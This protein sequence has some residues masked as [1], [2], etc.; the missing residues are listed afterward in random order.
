MRKLKLF[1]KEQVGNASD[2]GRQYSRPDSLSLVSRQSNLDK[3]DIET[4]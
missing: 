4:N 1:S 2:A 3:I